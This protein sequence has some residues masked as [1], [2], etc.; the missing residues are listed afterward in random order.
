MEISPA[1]LDIGER[2]VSFNLKKKDL[3]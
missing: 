2:G 1:I 3:K